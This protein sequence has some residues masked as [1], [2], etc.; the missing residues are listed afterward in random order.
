VYVC[1]CNVREER[2]NLEIYNVCISQSSVRV[3]V[4]GGDDDDENGASR[5]DGVSYKKPSVPARVCAFPGMRQADVVMD[6]V[7]RSLSQSKTK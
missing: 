7:L 5:R 2:K 6:P 1:G 4:L 3:V